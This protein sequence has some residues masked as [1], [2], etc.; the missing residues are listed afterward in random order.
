ME[1]LQIGALAAAYVLSA[2]LCLGVAARRYGGK[3]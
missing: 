2:V 1:P 3:R